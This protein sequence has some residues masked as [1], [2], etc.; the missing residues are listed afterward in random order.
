MRSWP[1]LACVVGKLVSGSPMA[2]FLRYQ[3]EEDSVIWRRTQ[4]ISYSALTL[5]FSR[6]RCQF[7]LCPDFLQHTHSFVVVV[8]SFLSHPF[9]PLL[10]DLLLLSG[11]CS[12]LAFGRSFFFSGFSSSVSFLWV[13]VGTISPF[14]DPCCVPARWSS[15][16]SLALSL[17]IVDRLASRLGSLVL[18]FAT[19]AVTSFVSVL[20]ILGSPSLIPSPLTPPTT[21][22]VLMPR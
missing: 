13:S 22:F 10:L 21:S 9:S 20:S 12:L 2:D 7:L 6:G 5:H 3:D 14:V 4:M 1:Q 15:A 18:P 17:L 19:R 8:F 11:S 16:P